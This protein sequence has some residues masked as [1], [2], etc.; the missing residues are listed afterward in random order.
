M[1]Y[2]KSVILFFIFSPF[3]VFVSTELIS[4]FEWR[5]SG[6]RVELEGMLYGVGPYNRHKI[7]YIGLYNETE[8]TDKLNGYYIVIVDERTKYKNRPHI[9]SM[10][11]ISGREH[12]KNRGKRILVADSVIASK[13]EIVTIELDS[14]P[15]YE[16]RMWKINFYRAEYRGDVIVIESRKLLPKVRVLS[17]IWLRS[18][19]FMVE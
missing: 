13:T 18:G 15:V 1:N 4:S 2:V 7:Y 9:G 3:I 5:T 14:L 8:N 12:I 19:A 16:N 17:G 10:V 11:R 6:P